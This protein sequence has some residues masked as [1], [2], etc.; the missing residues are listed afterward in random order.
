MRRHLLVRFRDNFGS[1][2]ITFVRCQSPPTA[3]NC[4][5]TA[6]DIRVREDVIATPRRFGRRAAKAGLGDCGDA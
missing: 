1:Y 3:F 2:L 6:A 4:C 5:W